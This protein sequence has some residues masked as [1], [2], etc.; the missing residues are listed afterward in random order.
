[1]KPKKRTTDTTKKPKKR[2][3]SSASDKENETS[4]QAST[5]T[6]THNGYTNGHTT[7]SLLHAD[8][9]PFT[10]TASSV[11]TPAASSSS[12]S[13]TVKHYDAYSMDFELEAALELIT[14][15]VSKSAAAKNHLHQLGHFTGMLINALRVFYTGHWYPE[16]PMKGSG[17]RCLRINQGNTSI[18]EKTALNSGNRWVLDSLP[19]EFTIWIDPGEVSYRIGEDGS[20][21]V[22]FSRPITRQNLKQ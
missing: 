10:S 8:T 11:S 17:H 16:R 6:E 18:I 9:P 3:S 20:V 22:H 15:F 19:K 1:M 14:R 12:S 2:R 4:Q 21:C 7:D 13:S 5:T